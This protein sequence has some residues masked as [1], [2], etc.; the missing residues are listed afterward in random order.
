M[1][2]VNQNKCPCVRH[3]LARGY[4]AQS[5]GYHTPRFIGTDI[6]TTQVWIIDMFLLIAYTVFLSL[7][8]G[9][10]SLGLLDQL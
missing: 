5:Q 2:H 7:A 8:C 9:P 6:R 10:Y 3:G 4:V 1:R